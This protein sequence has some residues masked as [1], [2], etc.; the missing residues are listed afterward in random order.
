MTRPGLTRLARLGVTL[1][2]VGVLAWQLDLTHSWALL[3]GARLPPVL[4]ALLLLAGSHLLVAL[5]WRLL[6]SRAGVM[7]TV[8]RAVRL[9]FAGLFLNNFFFGSVGGD[10]YRTWAARDRAGT[11][12]RA[13]A[14]TLLERVL[15]VAVLM[16]LG[17]AAVLI[18]AGRLPPT[19]AVTM[20]M[21]CGGGLLLCGLVLL[22][23]GLLRRL[24]AHLPGH[25]A[26]RARELIDGL[27][28]A[29]QQARDRRG[30]API[31]LLFL[32]AQI[33]RV[34][35]HGW[36]A[37]ALGIPI[38]MG[39]LFVVVPVVSVAA[40]LPITIGGLGIREGTGAVLL[41]PLGIAHPEAVALEF[42]AYLVG[43]ASS[44][45]GGAIFWLGREVSPERIEHLGSAA[46]SGRMEP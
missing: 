1:A 26:G 30:L 13:L 43:V 6:L 23:P 40:A 33:I 2:V 45:P 15:N 10:T 3:R 32:A 20:G 36:C 22:S 42:L 29:M 9:Y 37:Q 41:A 19:Y 17:L 4:A 44:L 8:E 34:W 39:D 24:A 28:E 12:R 7:V 5:G 27:L 11:G 18:G 31:V 35:T 14:A 21:I 16:L 38:P 46:E 25:R